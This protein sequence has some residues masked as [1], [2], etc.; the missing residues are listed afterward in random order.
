[1]EKKNP[2]KSLANIFLASTSLMFIF[3]II[4]AGSSSAT[5]TTKIGLI[6]SKEVV[7]VGEE[8]N[9]TVYIEPIEEV[10]GWQIYLLNFTQG[11]VNAN[12]VTSGSYW[13]DFFDPGQL[14]NDSGEI[15]DIQTWTT[16]PYPSSNHTACIIRFTALST[17][18]CEI[19]IEHVEITNYIFETMNLSIRNATV[20]VTKDETSTNGDGKNGHLSDDDGDGT[21]NTP[22]SAL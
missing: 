18:V 19:K 6:P 22:P 7:L 3:L 4:T 15:T 9:I 16:G 5:D 20:V 8:F 13:S 1:M 17:G 2:L 21:Y 14:D 12:E 11:T 10:S